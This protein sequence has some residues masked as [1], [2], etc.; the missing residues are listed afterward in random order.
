M[1]RFE[2]LL[3][4]LVALVALS[5]AF[6]LSACSEE[7]Q[8]NASSLI[9][10]SSS[11][12]QQSSSEKEIETEPVV[13]EDRSNFTI[14]AAT[15]KLLDRSVYD[16]M[17]ADG[18]S[19]FKGYLV[20]DVL[21]SFLPSYMGFDDS[22][23]LGPTFARMISFRLGND[24]N[25][26]NYLGAPVHPVMQAIL[27]LPAGERRGLELTPAQRATYGEFTL[28]YVYKWSIKNGKVVENG[29][30]VDKSNDNTNSTID[31]VFS[32][33]EQNSDG[34]LF[35]Y[36]V[37]IDVNT[38]DKIYSSEQPLKELA[39]SFGN[40]TVGDLFG[41]LL[42]ADTD[43]ELL[44][45]KVS[46]LPDYIDSIKEGASDNIQKFEKMK[47]VAANIP[48]RTFAALLKIE[49]SDEFGG[50]TYNGLKKVVENKVAEFEAT[51]VSDAAE[52][53]GW[54]ALNS[55]A[56][57][58]FVSRYG[59]LTFI[60]IAISGAEDFKAEYFAI[61]SALK[62]ENAAIKSFVDSGNDNVDKLVFS[63]ALLK[64][65]GEERERAIKELLK[66]VTP[67]DIISTLKKAFPASETQE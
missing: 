67:R 60:E 51:T 43:E 2:R 18:E 64:A 61:L 53:A 58:D 49:I 40:A 48:F 16:L 14:S 52:K 19:I 1:K 23:A 8:E 4:A 63:L 24:G 20:G 42:P 30:T 13:Y 12:S 25:W 22:S 17:T 5:C 6:M 29:V 31:L 45:M 44:A 50:Y 54:L 34:K 46:E 47:K 27:E 28:L 11:L 62:E 9:A 57:N 32:G 36:L 21:N 41:V 3:A 39:K 33:L 55:A 10:T 59:E 37:N 56:I 15:E 26:Y 65:E 38:F 66:E 7:E 35:G